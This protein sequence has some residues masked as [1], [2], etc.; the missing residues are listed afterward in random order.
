MCT[1]ASVAPTSSSDIHPIAAATTTS[2]MSVRLSDHVG[3]SDAAG[4][5]VEGLRLERVERALVRAHRVDEEEHVADDEKARDELGDAHR[6]RARGIG[7]RGEEERR[8]DEADRRDHEQRDARAGEARIEL[9]RAVLQAARELRGAEHEEQIADDRAGDRCLD[10]IDEPGAQREDRDDELREI[11]ERRV[12]ESTERGTGVRG[13]LLG[14]GA[15]QARE[16]NDR[17]R[18]R[19]RRRRSARACRN[20]AAMATGAAR[21]ARAASSCRRLVGSGVVYEHDRNVVAHLVAQ[22]IDGTDRAPTPT[23]D[24][25]AAPCT[26][27]T[28]EFRAA[29][30][31]ELMMC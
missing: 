17:D 13:E 20:D 4:C 16:R 21:G 29:A 25:R 6:R 22:A 15:Q 5:L 27:G 31:R 1:V 18:A 14:G 11:P 30:A 3:S 24:I 8:H 23:R 12:D 7:V 28:R 26:W 2:T 9:L 10:E 19:A